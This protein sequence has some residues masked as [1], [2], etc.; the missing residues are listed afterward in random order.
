MAAPTQCH[1]WVVEGL[2]PA[3]TPNPFLAGVLERPEFM[4]MSINFNNDLEHARRLFS[5]GLPNES[6]EA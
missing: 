5:V 6:E 3:A 1:S 2:W 4:P